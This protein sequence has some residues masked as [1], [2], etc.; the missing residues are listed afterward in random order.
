LSWVTLAKTIELM[1]SVS[2]QYR[3]N[4]IGFSENA[5]IFDKKMF[6]VNWKRYHDVSMPALGVSML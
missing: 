5:N 6:D 3:N 4:E 2:K 1:N